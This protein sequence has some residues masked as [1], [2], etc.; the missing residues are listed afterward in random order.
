[1]INYYENIYKF[2]KNFMELNEITDKN[3]FSTY[4]WL[5][6]NSPHTEHPIESIHHEFKLYAKNY[7]VGANSPQYVEKQFLSV[8]S[9]NFIKFLSKS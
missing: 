7:A 1:M 8:I 6:T 9:F 5:S 2:D 4:W 3:Y